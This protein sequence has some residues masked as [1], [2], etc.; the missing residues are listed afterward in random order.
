[1]TFKVG[2]KYMF[3]NKNSR[4]Y[5]DISGNETGN[6]A[7][8]QQYEYLKDAPSE[9]FFLHPLDNNYY[10]MINLNSGKVI[11]ISG[12]ETGNNANIQQF[13][14]LGD[15]P[16]EYWYFHREA[17]GYYVIESKHSGKVLDISG[18][19]TGNNANVQQFEFLADAPSERFAVEEAGSVSLPSIN[20]QPL[21]PVPQYETI[22]DQLPEETER[23]VTAFTIVPAISV[24]DPHYGEDTAK[25]I[26]ENPYY[27]VVKKQWWKKQ[28][29][30]V[31]APGE[32]YKYTSKTGI[33][34]TDQETATKTVS[35]SIG[36]D[37]GFS[38]KGF[39]VGMSSQY[40]TQL[41]A[42]I[43]HTTEQLKEETWD[44]E[45][46]NP[47]SNRM[48]YS[49]YILTT[50]YSVQRKNGTLVNSPWTMT[51]KT[52]THAVTYPN[53]EEKALN[54]NAKQLSKVESVN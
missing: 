50:E 7:N 18:N 40:S 13:E 34:V 11:D 27:M 37:M 2:M 21:S 44:H 41:Q 35:W 10:A 51:D 14:W 42:S 8:V 53:A 45:I 17:D 6:N 31:L 23:V 1:M 12:N 43:S 52:R 38:F 24:K 48:A 9:R 46:K 16:S 20:T 32:T 49:R 29:S 4:K 25:Q 36:A 47:S 19:E 39:S 22:N 30:Y 5:L 54:E 33:K 28:E 26:K 3:K 15:A